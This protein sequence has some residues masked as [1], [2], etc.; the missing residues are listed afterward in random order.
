MTCSWVGFS[1]LIEAAA[2]RTALREWFP[3]CGVMELA[4]VLARDEPW[5]PIVFEWVVGDAPDFPGLLD[6]HHFPG[7]DEEAIVIGLELGR[8]F[9]A[10]FGCHTICDGSGLGDDESPYWSVIWAGE[11]AHLADDCSTTF[12]DGEGGP[13]RVI[14]EIRIPPADLDES[15]RLMRP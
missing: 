6:L 12:G 7:T 5:P 15:G 11:V 3:R 13:V 2:I 9:A 10:R 14:R 1:R 8:R 4:E